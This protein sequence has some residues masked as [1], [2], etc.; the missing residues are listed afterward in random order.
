MIVS[1]AAHMADMMNIPVLGIVE[2]MSFVRCPDCGKEIHIFGKSHVEEVAAEFGYPLLS[3]IPIDPEI[4]ALV[5]AGKIEQVEKNPLY[6]A[7]EA[8]V[9]ALS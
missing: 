2:N 8:V 1:K 4:A 5:D 9:K 7:A 3:R 6:D